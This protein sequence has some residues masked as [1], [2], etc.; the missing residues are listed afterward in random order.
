MVVAHILPEQRVVHVADVVQRRLDEFDDEISNVVHHLLDQ[1][2]LIVEGHAGG[3]E[4]HPVANPAEEAA[5]VHGERIVAVSHAAHMVVPVGGSADGGLGVEVALE[6]VP[7]GA[8]AH[9][10]REVLRD[11]VL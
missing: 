3:L 2:R 8:V 7:R 6:L 11:G 5:A 9:G 4:A 1:V 10:E